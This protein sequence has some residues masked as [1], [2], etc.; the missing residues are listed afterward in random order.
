M[1][2]EAVKEGRRELH[3]LRGAEAYKYAW[4]ATD[5]MNMTRR[6]VPQ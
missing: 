6:L 1:I 4:G 2:E 5:R 3:F